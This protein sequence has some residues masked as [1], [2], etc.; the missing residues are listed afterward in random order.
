[1][2]FPQIEIEIEKGVLRKTNEKEETKKKRKDDGLK[3]ERERESVQKNGEVTEAKQIKGTNTPP[4][5]PRTFINWTHVIIAMLCRY[6]FVVLFL[7]LAENTNR[8]RKR[9]IRIV[10][11][12][13]RRKRE[14]TDKGGRRDADF[15]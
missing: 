5:L 15:S 10:V 11:N 7:L 6:F 12:E 14:R 4:S 9:K 13:R 1:M 8:N 3:R 2:C